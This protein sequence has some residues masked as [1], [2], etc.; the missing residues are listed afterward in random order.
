MTRGSVPLTDVRERAVRDVEGAFQ[1][2]VPA[3]VRALQGQQLGMLEEQQG[4]RL[5]TL[6]TAKSLL[7][8]M[9]LIKFGKL[10]FPSALWNLAFGWPFMKSGTLK[11]PLSALSRREVGN[12]T[13]ASQLPHREVEARGHAI[14]VLFGFWTSFI[15]DTYIVLA[16]NSRIKSSPSA[17]TSSGEPHTRIQQNRRQGHAKEDQPKS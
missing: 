4:G 12:R 5:G 3:K 15:C 6:V 8:F 1:A 10:C 17:S 9:C 7:V 11:V 16:W 13:D 14:S 2:E